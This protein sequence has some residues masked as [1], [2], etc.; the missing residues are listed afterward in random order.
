MK[1]M[2]DWCGLLSWLLKLK[3]IPPFQAR[4]I[5]TSLNSR[6]RMHFFP[7]DSRFLYFNLSLAFLLIR[8]QLRQAAPS[9]LPTL[10]FGRPKDSP[11]A[12]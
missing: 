1:R 3:T 12:C 9:F 11:G 8:C 6:P 2:I 5:I 7:S 10:E 4:I